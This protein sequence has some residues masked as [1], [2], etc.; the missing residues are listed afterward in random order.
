MKNCLLFQLPLCHFFI[1][2]SLWYKNFYYLCM[3]TKM[4]FKKK[5]AMV[6]N[7]NKN[8]IYF[9]RER[10]ERIIAG[11]DDERNAIAEDVKMLHNHI[12]LLTD[13]VQYYEHVCQVLSNAKD[14]IYQ[15]W[16]NAKDAQR[17][18]VSG[19]FDFTANSLKEELTKGYKDLGIDS[20]ALDVSIT[21]TTKQQQKKDWQ[22]EIVQYINR[23][24]LLDGRR[25]R[26]QKQLDKLNEVITGECEL[27]IST[28]IPEQTVSETPSESCENVQKKHSVR[29]KKKI[30]FLFPCGNAD[31]EERLRIKVENAI[32]K[33]T[34][35]EALGLIMSLLINEGWLSNEAS[36]RAFAR[37]IM[38]WCINEE[39]MYTQSGNKQPVALKSLANRIDERRDVEVTAALVLG[40]K[41][42]EF[43][44]MKDL[45]YFL[46]EEKPQAN[47]LRQA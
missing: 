18:K 19:S 15:K 35:R 1:K 44:F 25:G 36:S 23:L 33:N 10:L 28:D 11:I 2:I 30:V 42:P 3:L 12:E 40:E 8:N 6:Y 37:W 4:K 41:E 45:A 32:S 39:V 46:I 38:S 22:Q 43:I 29:A 21:L 20:I 5:E 26:F 7:R 31:L 14:T 24:T 9:E 27:Q 47:R 16:Q 34:K 13:T 17:Q